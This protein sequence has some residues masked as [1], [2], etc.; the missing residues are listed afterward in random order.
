MV[1][2][3][4]SVS[5][6]SS[7]VL[8]NEGEKVAANSPSEKKSFKFTKKKSSLS[9]KM[10]EEDSAS[11]MSRENVAFLEES[12][13][14]SSTTSNGGSG[15]G[16]GSSIKSVSDDEGEGEE[17]PEPDNK[18]KNKKKKKETKEPSP[19]TPQPPAVLNLRK[20]EPETTVI[21]RVPKAKA[22]WMYENLMKNPERRKAIVTD[23]VVSRSRGETASDGVDHDSNT[24]EI[25]IMRFLAD[26]AN[27][28]NHDG[29]FPMTY[30]PSIHGYGRRYSNRVN[31]VQTQ[32]LSRK[33][34]HTLLKGVARDFD[35]VNCFQVIALQL[36][37]KNNIDWPSLKY[38]VANQKLVVETAVS[39]GCSKAVV[40]NQHLRVLH[41][42]ASSK[43]KWPTTSQFLSGRLTLFK[44]EADVA[45]PRLVNDTSL[46]VMV[47]EKIISKFSSKKEEKAKKKAVEEGK[48]GESKEIWTNPFGRNIGLQCQN[49]EDALLTSWV[50]TAE[51]F[52]ADLRDIN[53]DGFMVDEDT[54]C[55]K[56]EADFLKQAEEDAYIATG[57]RV[58]LIHKSMDEAFDIDEDELNEC[59]RRVDEADANGEGTSLVILD[60]AWKKEVPGDADFN[61]P[62]LCQA[63]VEFEAKAESF[64]VKDLTVMNRGA[65][66]EFVN[67][68][69]AG[70]FLCYQFIKEKTIFPVRVSSDSQ[71][72]IYVHNPR[73]SNKISMSHSVL[74]NLVESMKGL[75]LKKKG[76]TVC[77]PTHS[78]WK[79]ICD[80]VRTACEGYDMSADIIMDFNYSTMGKSFYKNGYYDFA[81]GRFISRKED[82]QAVTMVR[83]ERDFWSSEEWS[84]LSH[85]DPSVKEVWDNL[86]VPFGIDDVE[87]HGRLRILARAQGGHFSDKKSRFCIDHGERDASKG[88]EQTIRKRAFGKFPSGYV[89]TGTAP[90]VPE[91]GVSDPALANKEVISSGSYLARHK[92]TNET[93]NLGGVNGVVLLDG[94]RIKMIEGADEI[95]G[96]VLFGKDMQ[97]VPIAF[98]SMAMNT[99]PPIKG[100]VNCLDNTAYFNL[101]YQF[102]SE[103][104]IST[105][106]GIPCLKKSDPEI[107]K[108]CNQP[109]WIKA[110]TWLVYNAWRPEPFDPSSVKDASDRNRGLRSERFKGAV[111]EIVDGSFT[112]EHSLFST[113]FDRP[114][115]DDLKN[116]ESFKSSEWFIPTHQ[117]AEIWR[118]GFDEKGSKTNIKSIVEGVKNLASPDKGFEDIVNC[119]KVAAYMGRLGGIV[120]KTRQYVSIG[121]GK[122]KQYMGYSGIRWSRDL[123]DLQKSDDDDDGDGE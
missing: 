74:L 50:K 43:T 40:K 102:V 7:S 63:V 4:S 28:P 94:E 60:D 95:T 86:I 26:A 121:G 23:H 81:K 75:M 59:Q 123:P 67:D 73:V 37:E 111:S 109:E 62:E 65:D 36:C 12:A 2:V 79:S 48:A 116:L 13:I 119:L 82:P 39:E 117:I 122:R 104:T 113:V 66:M 14:I 30:R 112:N 33:V 20:S 31:S 51:K 68:V 61:K 72:D 120:N 45:L 98:E 21:G 71:A 105:C 56:R 115:A 41:N 77:P 70:R 93:P 53:F 3:H 88:T 97:V 10:E 6:V 54:W 44:A 103:E 92:I 55:H 8:L 84:A 110:Y 108:K 46:G 85:D 96:R 90:I 24:Y 16:S 87:R 47:Q 89:T 99:V 106:K 9:S 114:N 22:L 64:V 5:N 76:G 78:E 27:N 15:S 118:R 17:E 25:L 35:G 1:S 49:V 34:R 38:Y 57:F 58:P 100:P 80:V 69:S 101:P 107:K 42:G 52:G 18:V 11:G 32:G 91:R 19:T 29:T 83:I